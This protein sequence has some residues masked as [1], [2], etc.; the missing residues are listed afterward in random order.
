VGTTRVLVF[1]WGMASSGVAEQWAAENNR[2]GVNFLPDLSSRRVEAIASKVLGTKKPGD[3]AIASIHWGSNW[4]YDIPREHRQF[5]RALIDRAGIDVVHGHSSHHPRGIEVYRGKPILYGC[6]DLINDYEGISGHEMFRSDLGLLYFIRF[7]QSSGQM[8]ALT[9]IPM[10]R[11]R[12]RLERAAN[13]D[14][15]WLHGTMDREC[16]ALGCRVQQ[17]DNALILGWNISG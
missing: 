6:G 17:Q 10:R 11:R 15:A 1:A 12:L 4:G 2:P 9:M 8:Q 16:R 14:A 7:D 5:A 3:I 13:E